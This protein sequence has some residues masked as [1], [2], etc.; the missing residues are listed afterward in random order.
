MQFWRSVFERRAPTSIAAVET[1]LGAEL[2]QGNS[3]HDF[4][5]TLLEA[6]SNAYREAVTGAG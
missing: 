4:P 3:T 6:I 5:D 2:R 1:A